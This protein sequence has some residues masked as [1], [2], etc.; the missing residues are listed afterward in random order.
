MKLLIPA[1][2]CQTSAFS[3]PVDSPQRQ[4]TRELFP[5][6]VTPSSLKSSNNYRRGFFQDINDECVNGNFGLK[7]PARSAPTSVFSSPNGSPRRLDSMDLFPSFLAFQEFQHNHVGC[8]SKV[9]PT[10]T[11]PSPDPSPLPGTIHP[12][13]HSSHK[14]L[15]RTVFPSHHKLVSESYAERP[16]ISAHPLPLPPGAIPPPQ[17][18]MQP[19]H[20]IEQPSISSFTGQWIKG[21]LIGRGTFGSVYLAT[22]RYATL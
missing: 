21:K 19:Q 11:M 14:S 15:N 16:E 9:S 5:S 12:N 4:N 6:C 13:P 17:S 3:S 1:R 18:T 20:V 10:R 2:S 7:V 8:Y 22:N